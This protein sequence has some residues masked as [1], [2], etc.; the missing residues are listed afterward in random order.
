MPPFIVGG[1]LR[2][3]SSDFIARKPAEEKDNMFNGHHMEPYVCGG[4]N[5]PEESL[6]KPSSEADGK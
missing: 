6:E 4:S 5:D 3:P 2:L 1:A